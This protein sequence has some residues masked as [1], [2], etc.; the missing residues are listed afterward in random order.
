MFYNRPV[1]KLLR[2]LKPVGSWCVDFVV[3]C[4]K[5]VWW[6]IKAIG[7]T[8]HAIAKGVAAIFCNICEALGC[9]SDIGGFD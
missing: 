4:G 5:A 2:F 3:G 1:K 6:V 8:L 9:L 7:N